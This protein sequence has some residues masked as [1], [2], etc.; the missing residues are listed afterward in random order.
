MLTAE[1]LVVDKPGQI[2]TQVDL[3][4]FKL[5]TYLGAASQLEANNR[6]ESV[7]TNN[8]EAFRYYSLGVE[9]ANLLRS[10][11]AQALFAKAIAL[12]PNF[13][14]APARIG[15]VVGVIGNQ[16]GRAKP[17]LQKAFQLSDR[18]TEKDRLQI[19]AWYAT[20]NFD[21]AT[22]IDAFRR[23][24]SAHPLEV[25]A[26]RRLAALLKGEERFLEAI[27]V[28]KQALVIDA[29]AKD[30][31]NGLGSL[32]SLQGRPDEAIAMFQRYVQLAPDEPN[33]HDSLGLGYQWAGRCEEAIQEYERSL[34]LKPDFEIAIVH[35][36]NLYF[37]HGR[38]RAA[39]EQYTRYIKVAPSSAERA[40]GYFGLGYIEL[41]RG[42]FKQAARA[43]AQA[44]KHDKVALDLPYLLALNK[45]DL[46][47]AARLKA[48]IEKRSTFD[49]GARDSLRPLVFPRP[50]HLE[51]GPGGRSHSK[52]QA[53]HRPPPAN[54][55]C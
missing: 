22:A 6:V 2:L 16:P 40:R 18:L 8:L 53:G 25:E 17:Y 37:H 43:A 23:L 28:L 4:S 33:S 3:L 51:I 15:Y 9:K 42:N 36:A 12:D 52:L 11:E 26:Y 48:E 27:E 5:R 24:V 50:V 54:L 46:S 7:M 32:Y 39:I 49:R 14:M 38:Y 1:R 13:A 44:L 41:R 20:V 19:Q 30:L 47:T 29:G 21:Y 35:L 55:E 34:A 10:E 45:D 31:Y